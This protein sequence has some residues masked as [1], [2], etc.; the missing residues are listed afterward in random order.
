MLSTERDGRPEIVLLDEHGVD[1]IAAFIEDGNPAISFFNKDQ[2]NMIYIGVDSN[3]LPA[4]LL[5]G[6][7]GKNSLD[8]SLNA[9]G[10]PYAAFFDRSGRQRISGGMSMSGHPAMVFFDSK[11]QECVSIGFDA[12]GDQILEKRSSGVRADGE[13]EASMDG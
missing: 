4:I 1:R 7:D 2:I 8:V 10:E 5:R 12:N 6:S 11:G 3:G 13:P 9:N